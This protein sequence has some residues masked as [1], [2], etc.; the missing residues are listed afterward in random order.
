MRVSRKPDPE[1][2]ANRNVDQ[3]VRFRFSD[4]AILVLVA[5]SAWRSELLPI[6][7]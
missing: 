2:H 1:C 4:G 6:G 5:I 3:G 7:V